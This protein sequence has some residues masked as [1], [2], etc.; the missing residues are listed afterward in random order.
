M[1][2]TRVWRASLA[3]V[4]STSLERSGRV[5]AAVLPVPVCAMPMT[6]APLLTLGMAL[7]W[8]GVGVL[9]PVS[10]MALRMRSWS[11]S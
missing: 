7:S 3:S 4:L 5:K 10:W 11:G 9:Y 6:S 2:R 8:M 1:M